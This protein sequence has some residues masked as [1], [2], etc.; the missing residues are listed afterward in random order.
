MG[1]DNIR[2]GLTFDDVL[3]VPRRSTI[4][5]RHDVSFRTR[6]SRNISLEIPVIAANMDT[7]V[8]PE[9][10]EVLIANGTKPIFHRFCD[11]ETQIDWVKRFGENMFISAGLLDIDSVRTLLDAGAAGPREKAAAR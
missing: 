2:T 7:V 4:R 10:A 9:L 3:L 8:G 11:L 5:S 1:L 6:L